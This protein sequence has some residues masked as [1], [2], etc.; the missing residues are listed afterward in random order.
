MKREFIF[1]HAHKIDCKIIKKRDTIK[2]LLLLIV[3][4]LVKLLSTD[5]NHLTAKLWPLQGER[6]MVLLTPNIMIQ[7]KQLQNSILLGNG[8]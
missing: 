4:W 7:T 1:T 3:V 8:F 5:E 2:F 6:G